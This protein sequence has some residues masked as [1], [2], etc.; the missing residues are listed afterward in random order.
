MAAILE[1]LRAILNGNGTRRKLAQRSRAE[2]WVARTRQKDDYG[3]AAL[4]WA[5]GVRR[6]EEQGKREATHGAG[7]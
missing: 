3:S 6:T 4:V 2:A 7:F 5:E 1:D